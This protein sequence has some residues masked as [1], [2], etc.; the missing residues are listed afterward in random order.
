MAAHHGPSEQTFIDGKRAARMESVDRM[1]PEVR[2]LVHDFGLN[3]V[4]AMLDV[5][6]SKPKHIRHLVNTVLDEFSPTRGS[7]GAQGPRTQ[8]SRIEPLDSKRTPET[9]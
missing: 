7:Y 2:Q 4:K 3:V 5:G 8:L 1:S 9:P 6:V